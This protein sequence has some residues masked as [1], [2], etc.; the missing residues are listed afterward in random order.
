MSIKLVFR[1]TALLLAVSVIGFSDA[2]TDEYAKL[3]WFALPS[4]CLAPVR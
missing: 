1:A 4:S 3:R 2:T